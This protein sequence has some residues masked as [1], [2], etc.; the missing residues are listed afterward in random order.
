MSKPRGNIL[1]IREN[2]R[3]RQEAKE[4]A[5]SL[6]TIIRCPHTEIPYIG[7]AIN[8]FYVCIG[9][10]NLASLTASF[11]GCDHIPGKHELPCE[12][13]V[14]AM[15]PKTHMVTC[16]KHSQNMPRVEGLPQSRVE[17]LH[18][19]DLCTAFCRQDDHDGKHN[20]QVSHK[21]VFL[22]GLT[23]VSDW[24]PSFL[25]REYADMR[26][27]FGN[28][29]TSTTLF[30]RS[31]RGDGPTIVQ[32]RM[33]SKG[34]CEDCAFVC[35]G[36]V[37]GDDGEEV[38]S[39]CEEHKKRVNCKECIRNAT[40]DDGHLSPYRH[41]ACMTHKSV[42]R[43]CK[44]ARMPGNNRYVCDGCWK[45]GYKMCYDCVEADSFLD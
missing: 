18:S 6:G 41:W 30:E 25:I 27:G 29:S 40:R 11:I 39:C 44:G 17:F 36:C 12:G 26:D 15:C 13:R 20:F 23:T 34:I 8:Q 10:G 4:D 42:E 16:A 28:A 9:D 32:C 43:R 37:F 2:K 3:K 5:E 24:T 7:E 14:I 38:I 21:L 22:F 1:K 19:C 45:R 33:C 31:H 35:E